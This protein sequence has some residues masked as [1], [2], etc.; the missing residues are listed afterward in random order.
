MRTA[1]T[2]LTKIVL[3]L[4]LSN[5]RFELVEGPT[6]FVPPFISTL[7]LLGYSVSLLSELANPAVPFVKSG[8][9]KLSRKESLLIFSLKN[10]PLNPGK[11]NNP[12]PK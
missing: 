5:R 10:F 7:T 9:A 2:R 4:S 1:K 3:S 11:I 6:I 8:R 12:K